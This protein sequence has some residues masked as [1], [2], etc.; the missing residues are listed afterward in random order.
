[1][2]FAVG[3]PTEEEVGQAKS[4]FLDYLNEEV[5][6]IDEA[7]VTIDE[8]DEKENVGVSFKWYTTV[9][10]VH[11]AVSGLIDAIKDELN[12]ATLTL[13][14]G[15]DSQAFNL[16]DGNVAI[17]VARY[18]LDGKS[19]EKFLE[20]KEPVT[21]SYKVKATNKEGVTFNLEGS[22]EFTV[23]EPTEE[24]ILEINIAIN[25]N[26]KP[27]FE[28]FADVINNQAPKSNPPYKLWVEHILND[29]EVTFIFSEEAQGMGPY[30]G[31]KA[32]G[33][34]TAFYQL[35]AV[36]EIQ[37]ASAGGKKVNFKDENGNVRTDDGFEWELYI[38]GAYLIGDVPSKIEGIIGSDQTMNLDCNTASG[39]EFPVAVTFHFV[40][41]EDQDAP[42]SLEGVAP[43]SQDNNDG[44]IIGVDNTMEYRL[45]GEDK[46]TAVEKDATEI[47]GLAAGTYKVRYAAKGGYNAGKVAEVE[48]PENETTIVKAEIATVT[49]ENGK[50][51]IT[52]KEKPTETPTAETFTATIAISMNTALMA[53]IW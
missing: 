27:A 8:I 7:A 17:E 3:V 9:D 4:A 6:K 48:V 25:E 2:E 52:L 50:V 45:Q 5:G 22:L 30:A 1:L 37:G 32:T 36:Q 42:T 34:K 29:L 28:A 40:A 23:G 19:S 35:A 26:I 12:T 14:R 53:R 13:I 24:E 38:F 44:K 10:E 11:Q 47:T 46:W 16:N 49:A 18:L 41:A 43:T 15:E 21:A 31:L 51:S 39:I 20:D 33:L